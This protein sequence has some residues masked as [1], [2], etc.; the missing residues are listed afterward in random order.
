MKKLISFMVA[1]VFAVCAVC[2]VV[3]ADGVKF[4]DL[5]S[6]GSVNA[7]DALMVLQHATGIKTLADDVQAA[8]DVDGDEK[9]VAG[10]A[11]YI[12]QYS[13]GLIEKF[14]AEIKA[15]EPKVPTTTE[16]I[17]DYYKSVA[18]ANSDVVTSQSFELVDIEI[19]KPLLSVAFKSLAKLVL[20]SNTVEVSGFPGDV[21]KLTADDIVSA[22][23]VQND[24]GT[25]TLN[26]RIK[27]QTD[28]LEGSKYEGPVGRAIGVVGNIPQVVVETGVDDFVNVDNASG[29]LAYEDAFI[30]VTVDEN[31]K[32]VKGSCLWQYTVL[33]DIQGFDISYS[34][35]AINIK[36]GAA[37]GEIDYKLAY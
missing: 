23:F 14:P 2:P 11:L 16:E 35:L 28:T 9:I 37:T 25:V 8:A 15:E 33:G 24:N 10:D 17:L 29:E 34:A 21:E 3:I 31:H 12:L 36:N 18:M 6:S 26:I 22:T 1:A 5:D 20:D 7:G 19:N 27:A 32:L 13:A 30:N 4:G